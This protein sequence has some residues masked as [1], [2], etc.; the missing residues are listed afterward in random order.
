MNTL[1]IKTKQQYFF[2]KSYKEMRKLAENWNKAQEKPIDTTPAPNKPE[3]E[4]FQK[5]AKSQ[6]W[7]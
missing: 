3:N 5:Y 1:D 6:G 4:D 7:N 2:T